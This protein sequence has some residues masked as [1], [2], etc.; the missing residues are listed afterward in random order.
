MIR[1]VLTSF[2]GR[3]SLLAVG[4]GLA[5]VTL[6]A[7]PASA[8]ATAATSAA[9]PV[10]SY[11]G[12]AY[13]R[14]AP[15]A[16]AVLPVARPRL[17]P[18]AD[19]SLAELSVESADHRDIVEVG[20]VR[21]RGI[22]GG[23]RLFVSY[24][25]AG[26]DHVD[27]GFRSASAAYRPFQAL[28]P[29]TSIRFGLAYAAGGWNISVQGHRIGSFPGRLWAGGFRRASTEQAFGE[30]ESYGHSRTDMIDGRADRAISGFA[31]TG[32]R[33]PAGQ[34]YGSAGD[35]YYLGAHGGTWFRLGGP[36]R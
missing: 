35:G 11:V 23:P 10:F 2:S 32:A 18:Q 31:L 13:H 1:T 26:R 9:P 8:A 17:A 7:G 14:S 20:W 22:A 30:V 28:R 15:G 3:L 24:W 19:H 4:A 16:S 5:A 25:A 12:E 33:T 27:A 21:S 29:G 36:G 6:G 34:F